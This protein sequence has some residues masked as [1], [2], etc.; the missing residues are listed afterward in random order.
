MLKEKTL[1]SA[2][3]AAAV[4]ISVPAFA[5]DWEDDYENERDSRRVESRRSRDRAYDD[6][7]DR[8]TR[9]SSRSRDRDYDDYED[10]DSRRSRRSRDRDYDE[11]GDSDRAYDNSPAEASETTIS[12]WE[13]SIQGAYLMAQDPLFKGAGSDYEID[14]AGLAMTFMKTTSGQS[15]GLE[16]GGMLVV[17]AGT[18]E[19]DGYSSSIEWT[20]V[21]VMFGGKLGLRFSDANPNSPSLSVGAM[22]GADYRYVKYE[23]SGYYSRSDDGSGVG[24]F[25]GAYISGELPLSEKFAIR[26]SVN[27]LCTQNDG[28]YEDSSACEDV[29]YLMATAGVVFRW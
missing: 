26:A 7:E 22:L 18:A 15:V 13:F 21:D 4:M 25:Y 14:M 12:G 19:V 11:W 9:R 1:L 20:Q 3:V 16:G 29:S 28:W 6:Y 24:L 2:L 23:M 10:R 17:S 5:D 8:E 27:Y